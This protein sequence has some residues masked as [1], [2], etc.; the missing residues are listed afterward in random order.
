M[1]NQFVIFVMFYILQ[2]NVAIFERCGGKMLHVSYSKFSQLS[3]SEKNE[4]LS[5]IDKVTICNAMSSF[6][7]R[8]TIARAQM[9]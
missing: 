1:Y 4:N 6:F 5:T 8:E 2:G 3:N 9:Q 7:G